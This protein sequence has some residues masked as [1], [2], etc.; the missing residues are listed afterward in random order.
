MIVAP[1]KR[2]GAPLPDLTA[3]DREPIHALG[4]IQPH[5]VLIA[6]VP[7]GHRITHI[8]AN[9]DRSV[10]LSAEDCLDTN[11]AELVGQGAFAAMEQSLREASYGPS[12]VLKLDLP[13]PLSPRR[14]ILVHRHAGRMIL[15]LEDAPLH[16][17]SGS[18]LWKA[19]NIIAGLRHAQ[20]VTQL[21]EEAVREIRK[22]TGY[23]RVMIYQ[24]D[25]AGHGTV[26][27]EDK[28][29]SLVPFLHLRFPASDIPA[30]ARR[31]YVLQRV[32]AIP[33]VAY[34]PV[35]L[36]SEAGPPL[37]MSFCALRG[38][39]PVHL[40]YL[41]N[42]GVR[43]SFSVSL[44]QGDALW[45]LIA[46]HHD[47]KL[48]P[49]A[50]LRA[51]CDVIGQ[52]L[53]LLIVR[54]TETEALAVRL[55]RHRMNVEIRDNMDDTLGVAASLAHA[56]NTILDLMSAGGALVQCGCEVRL[57]G[58]TPPEGEARAMVAALLRTSDGNAT[59]VSDAGSPRGIAADYA[60]TA[61]GILVMPLTE[62][63]TD[64]IA[65]F[66]PELPQTVRWGGNPNKP[67][68]TEPGSA[69]L[70]PRK[71]FAA[72]S[73]LLLG[74]S[75]AWSD[76]D[77]LVASDLQRIIANALLHQAEAKLAQLSAYDHL[78]G[79]ANRRTMEAQLARWQLEGAP[80]AAAMLFI[81]LDRFKAVN[82]SLGH[83]AGDECLVHVATRLRHFGT[84]HQH[85][86]PLRRRRIRHFLA[87][88]HPGRCEGAR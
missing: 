17:D 49:S 88:C 55:D 1:G 67:V 43:A 35:P 80:G 79:L 48:M 20:T 52:L 5:G 70:S 14:K 77:L 73:E 13:F 44:L 75:Q 25:R 78:T 3:C 71:S 21:C 81:D 72:W 82:D 39:S 19:Q 2:P 36:L 61:S 28:T 31:L 87:R 29:D 38:I 32:R 30:Q 26:V 7:E 33:D 56:S 11:L 58:I 27:A 85:G 68:I 50:D 37:D 57:I 83:S 63:G 22:L 62:D 53:S 24:F 6:T 45:G 86:G 34:V 40:E 9:F 18:A 42:M 10:G 8:S 65:W 47:T 46:C 51:L 59:S 4:H 84:R 23:D 76:I 15:E 74:R 66:R 64:T 54:V 16:D 12:N 41:A 60:A 69:R